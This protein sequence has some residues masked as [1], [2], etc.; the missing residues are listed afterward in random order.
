MTA[1][2]SYPRVFV[3]SGPS[4]VG[5][6][7]VCAFLRE[8]LADK[9]ALST[10]ATSRTARP[11]ER[12]GVDYHFKTREEFE[13]MIKDHEFVEYAE[14][15]GNYYG[16]PIS[17]IRDRLAIGASVLLEI[18]VQGAMQVKRAFDDACLIFIEPPS[19]AVLAERLTGRGTNDDADIQNRLKIAQEELDQRDQFD[20]VITNDNLETCQ[21]AV[22]AI[23]Q[24]DLLMNKA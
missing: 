18:E 11:N 20:Y 21:Q 22:L 4:G 2:T 14:Y 1:S 16:T 10:S 6:G 5:K 8:R 17:S 19:M 15:N 23:I 3:I 12:D 7:T 24:K 13:Q 9:M